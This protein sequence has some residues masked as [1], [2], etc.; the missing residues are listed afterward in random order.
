MKYTDLSTSALEF[1]AALALAVNAHA[2]QTD[3]QGEPY[4]LHVIRVMLAVPQHLRP[5]ALLHD[6]VEDTPITL[7]Y[8]RWAGFSPVTVH[9]VDLLSRPEGM[10]YGDYIRRLSSDDN[11]VVIKVADMSDNYQRGEAFP[12]L[13]NRYKRAFWLLGYH[14]IAGQWRKRGTAANMLARLS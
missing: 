7:A 12:S 2:A 9:L 8:L 5:A 13:R 4:I 10:E 11:A 14:Y 3:N 6:V 1:Q